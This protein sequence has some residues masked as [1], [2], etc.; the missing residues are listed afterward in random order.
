MPF[1]NEIEG[2]TRV[3][4]RRGRVIGYFFLNPGG[5]RH[6]PPLRTP[7]Y[8]VNAGG[9]IIVMA[10]SESLLLGNL[11]SSIESR[12]NVIRGVQ[13]PCLVNNMVTQ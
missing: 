2:N 8:V 4:I 3:T 5:Y 10:S 12:R 7:L 13:R 1:I 6:I 11:S 9:M